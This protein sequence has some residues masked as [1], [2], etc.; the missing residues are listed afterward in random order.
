MRNCGLVLVTLGLCVF[1]ST[2]T[3]NAH[4]PE[5]EGVQ[6]AHVSSDSGWLATSL[7]LSA[8]YRT[9][10]LNWHIA[11]NRQGSDP[12]IRSELTWSDIEIYQVKVTARTVVRDKIYL[13]AA[14]DY[15][16]VIDGDNRDSDYDGD[17]RTLEFS[18]SDNGVDGNDVWDATIGI[19]PRFSFFSDALVVSPLIGYAVSAQDLNIVDGH[20]TLSTPPSTVPVGPIGDLDSRYET[21]WKGPW[22]GVDLMFSAPIATGPFSMFRFILSGEYH[23][24]D[25]EAE[26]NWNL[27]DDFRHPLSFSHDA[28]GD[29][30][31][32]AAEIFLE[33]G[34]RWGISMGI[35][36]TRM[37]ADDGVDRVYF[38]DGTTQTVQLNDVRWRTVTVEAGLTFRF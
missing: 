25:Y 8:G 14:L 35:N 16:T 15:G 26:A 28:D 20:Q 31:T 23:W 2:S 13:R 32:V 6:T 1:F 19:G 30:L 10:R 21:T 18:R 17:D 27:R 4:T 9:D 22:A 36:M 37:T 7:S 5:P 29:G 3:V 24:V 12:N 11:G 33:A 34:R 38:A